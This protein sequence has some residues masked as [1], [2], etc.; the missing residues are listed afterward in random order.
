[1][2]FSFGAA[3]A[4][5]LYV[6]GVFFFALQGKKEYTKVKTRG[7]RKFIKCSSFRRLPARANA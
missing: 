1:M 3:S 7:L 6:Y 5:V 2:V 4:A